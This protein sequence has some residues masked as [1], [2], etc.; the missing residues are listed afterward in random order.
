M[1]DRRLIEASLPLAAISE[2]SAREKSIRHGHI[3]TLH[4]WWARRPLAMMRAAVLAALMP[5]PGDEEKREDMEKLAETI[6]NWDHVKDGN[7]QEIEEARRI[8]RQQFPGRPPRLLDPFMGSGETGLEALRLGCETYGIDINPVAHLIEL[9]TLVYPQQYGRSEAL[10]GSHKVNQGKADRNPLSQDILKWGEWVLERAQRQVGHLYAN[11]LGDEPIV[12]YLWSRTMRCPNPACGAE[13][14]LVRDGW[15]ANRSGRKI[16]LQPVADLALRRITLNIIELTTASRKSFNPSK[17][18]IGTQGITCLVCGQTANW[19]CTRQEAVARRIG[20]RPLAVIYEQDGGTQG[21]RLFAAEDE[22]LFH[23]AEARLPEWKSEIPDEP[24]PVVDGMGFGV[25]HYGLTHWRDLFNARQLVGLAALCRNVADAYYTM[26][27]DGMDAGRAKA[28]ATYLGLALDRMVGLGSS[29]VSWRPTTESAVGLFAVRF[30]SMSW[31][32]AEINLCGG[33]RGAWQSALA[34]IS[35]AVAHSSV[36]SDNVAVLHQGDAADL[37]YP[38]EHFDV[39]V[40]DL[41]YYNAIP[42]GDLSDFFYV[43]L[44]RSAGFLYPK[45]FNLTGVMHA[46]QIPPSQRN[47]S[48][49][50]SPEQSSLRPALSEISR[51]LRRDGIAVLVHSAGPGPLPAQSALETLL[52]ELRDAH[53]VVTGISPLVTE[54]LSLRVQSQSPVTAI[55]CACRKPAPNPQPDRFLRFQ[56]RTRATVRARLAQL[57]SRGVPPELA[58]FCALGPA[59]QLWGQCS[60]VIKDSGE[61]VIPPEVTQIVRAEVSDLSICRGA[62]PGCNESLAVAHARAWIRHG[63]RSRLM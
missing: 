56:A 33:R 19:S 23:D 26:I 28:V 3:S 14:P 22:A 20:Q 6:V 1:S 13:I 43:W 38:D 12:G 21:Y 18:N 30:F 50:E 63:V 7:S 24:I 4:I 42:Y 40:T 45:S 31:T 60:D 9:C 41:P 54:S 37:P 15:L 62:P 52:A 46:E 35:E 2:Q 51:C 61:P 59:F 44:K 57:Q 29:L 48:V 27:A 49:L 5:D 17:L 39:I 58:F 25:Q 55:L 47:D 16:A 11:P 32:Y 36:A 53:L 10:P 8:I 34:S